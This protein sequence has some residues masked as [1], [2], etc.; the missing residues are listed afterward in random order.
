MLLILEVQSVRQED[1]SFFKNL[2]LMHYEHL[3]VPPIVVIGL[4][5]FGSQFVIAV[6]QTLQVKFPET[7]PSL[8]SNINFNININ[9]L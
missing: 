1:P 5:E 6:A 2:P 3:G 4:Q 8:N 7:D 9:Y